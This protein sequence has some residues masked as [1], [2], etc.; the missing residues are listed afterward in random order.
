[1]AWVSVSLEYSVSQ[2]S[3]GLT[4]KVVVMKPWVM[5]VIE[6]HLM[7]REYDICG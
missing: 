1:M 3:V 7:T 5:D 2:I 6:S 4:W